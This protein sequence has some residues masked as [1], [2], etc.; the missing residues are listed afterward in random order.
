MEGEI[1]PV[2]G[3]P[4]IEGVT[5]IDNQ[6]I[7]VIDGHSLFARHSPPQRVEQPMSCRI[8]QDSDWARTILG[9]LVEAAGYRIASE[10]DAAADVAIVLDETAEEA[11][12]AGARSVIRLRQEPDTTGSSADTIYRYDRD[13][14]LAALKQVRLGRTA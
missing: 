10:A 7:P 3:D 13:A 8:P 4:R 12:P 9:P 6:P 1:V 14:L 11:T 5:L 2:D